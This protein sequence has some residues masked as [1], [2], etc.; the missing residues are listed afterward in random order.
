VLDV[1][2]GGTDAD[3]IP[4]GVA[5]AVALLLGAAK[6]FAWNPVT[7]TTGVDKE[8]NNPK[9]SFMVKKSKQSKQW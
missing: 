9:E 8:M 6:W 5:R 7:T 3:T 4:I 2:V 1:W